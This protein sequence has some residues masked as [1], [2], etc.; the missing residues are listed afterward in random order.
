MSGD[1][2]CRL[3]KELFRRA[4]AIE[5]KWVGN[6]YHRGGVGGKR[7]GLPGKKVDFVLGE[8]EGGSPERYTGNKA[9]HKQSRPDRSGRGDGLKGR[10][11]FEKTSFPHV[12]V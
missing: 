4:G 11:T 10:C 8:V 5:A 6:N 2:L 3:G 9:K 7:G 12:L 1:E